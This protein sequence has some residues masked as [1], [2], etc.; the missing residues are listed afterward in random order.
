MSRSVL[1]GSLFLVFAMSSSLAESDSNT[2]LSADLNG[3]QSVTFED[4]FLFGEQFGQRCSNPDDCTALTADLDGDQSVT[5]EDFFVFVEQFGQTLTSLLQPLEDQTVNLGSSLS[6]QL[7]PTEQTVLVNVVESDTPNQPPAFSDVTVVVEPTIEF[8]N[9]IPHRQLD[10]AGTV[11]DP[12]DNLAAITM[13]DVPLAVDLITQQ[14]GNILYGETLQTRIGNTITD[15]E[16]KQPV[17]MRA[18][19][20]QGALGEIIQLGEDLTFKEASELVTLKR[21]TPA[22]GTVI[23]ANNFSVSQEITVQCELEI[24]DSNFRADQIVQVLLDNVPI[25]FQTENNFVSCSG[26]VA[27]SPGPTSTDEVFITILDEFQNGFLIPVE[28]LLE[29]SDNPN[30]APRILSISPPDGSLVPLENSDEFVLDI[31]GQLQDLE[32]NLA[33][34]RINGV[35]VLFTPDAEEHVHNFLGLW[36]CL[37]AVN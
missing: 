33:V 23:T 30:Q 26:Q 8:I 24:E 6:L 9:G 27:L 35:E 18:L 19:D 20:L 10:V 13:N 7:K 25:E 11:N 2:P 15:A 34:V 32:D 16:I 37:L 3:D 12:N 14:A 36:S 17:V 4:F 22:P 29:T 1:C 31:V 28:Y 21:I 5:F